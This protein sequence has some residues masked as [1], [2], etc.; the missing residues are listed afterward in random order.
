MIFNILYALL[1]LI[2]INLYLKN[3]DTFQN[4]TV[5]HPN[6]KNKD[7]ELTPFQTLEYLKV[8]GDAAKIQGFQDKYIYKLNQQF[9]LN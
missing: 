9:K 7:N 6:V 4:F 1:I 2:I 3:I 8:L 5:K